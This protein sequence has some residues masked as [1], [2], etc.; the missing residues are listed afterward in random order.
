MFIV[1]DEGHT[2]LLKDL[3]SNHM[4]ELMAYSPLGCVLLTN[5]PV[6]NNAQSLWLLLNF[7]LP[8]IFELS[9]TTTL[10]EDFFAW[11]DEASINQHFDVAKLREV[12]GK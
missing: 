2:D 6:D 10:A 7:V 4:K 1:A 11:L 3:N 5:K 9:G 8:T 12:L